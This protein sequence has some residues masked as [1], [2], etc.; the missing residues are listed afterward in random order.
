MFA[1]AGQLASSKY[2]SCY[3]HVRLM[4]HGIHLVD[5][6]NV[7]GVLFFWYFFVTVDISFT[8][9]VSEQCVGSVSGCLIGLCISVPFSPLISMYL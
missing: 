8:F 6:C 9:L 2:G 7:N 1:H 3:W 5:H 4:S